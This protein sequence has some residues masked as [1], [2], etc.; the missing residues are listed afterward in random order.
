MF[1]SQLSKGLSLLRPNLQHLLR[2]QIELRRRPE[3]ELLETRNLLATWTPLTNLAP[4]GAGVMMLLTDGRVMMQGGGVT[5]AWSQ[6]TP[7]ATGSYINGTWSALDSMGL[8]RLYFASNVLPSGDVFVVGGEYSGPSGASNIPNTGEIYDPVTNTWS[9]IAPFPLPNFGD[10]PTELLADGSVLAGYIFDARTFLYNPATNSWSAAG[11][12]LR[13]DRSDEETW[14]KLPDGSV[15]SYDVFS[16]ISTGV[17]H[18]QRYIPSTNTWVDAGSF[19]AP[20]LSSSATGDELG[21]ALLLPDGRVFQI[22]SNGNTALYTPSTNTWTAGPT[23]PNAKGA[24][25]A[26]GAILPNGHVIFAADSFSPTFSPPTQVFDF[27]PVA[28]TITQ[29]VLPAALTTTLNGGPAFVTRMLMLPNGD[30]LFGT[31]TNRLWEYTPDGSPNASWQPT[32]SSVVLDG[33]GSYT[34]T[35]TQLSGISEGASY[36]DDAEMSSNYPIVQLTSSSGVVTYARTYNWTSQVAMGNT[37]ATTQFMLPSAPAAGDYSLRVIANGIASAPVDFAL[38]LTVSSSTPAN[39]GVVTSQTTSFIVNFNEAVVPTSVEASDLQVNGIAADGVTLNSA[40]T[41]ATFTFNTSPVTAQGVQNMAIA[42][43]GITG[44]DGISNAGFNSSFRYDALTLAV[45]S[46]NPPVG[47]TI[48]IPP[49]NFNFD[50]TFNEPID[51]ATV[52]PTDLVLSQGTVNAVTVLAGNETVRYTLVGM[53]T[54]GTLTVTLPAGKVKDAFDN[55][56]FTAFSATYSLDIGTAPMPAP[57]TGVQPFGSLVYSSSMAGLINNVTDTDNFTLN[58]DAGQTI[59]VVMHPTTLGLQPSVTLR[60]P[61][62]GVLGTAIAQAANQDAILE[63]LATT[64]G[65]VYTITAG[66]DSATT[67]GY[68]VQVILNGLEELER[69]NGQLSNNTLGTA[70]NLDPSFLALQAGP[71]NAARAAVLGNTDTYAAAAVTPTFTD[72][73]TTGAK[74]TVAIGDNA[75]NTLTSGQLAGFTIAF[76]GAT[77]ESLSFSTNGLITFTTADS[78]AANTD[79]SFSPSEP[80]IAP[81][82]D[83]LFIENSGTGAASRNIYWQLIGSGASQQLIIQWNNARQVGGTTY[84][85]FEA[86]LSRDG[87]VQF[88]YANTVPAAEIGS[89]TVGVKAAGVNSSQRLLVSFNQAAGSLV[90]PGLSTLLSATAPTPDFY[91]F[92]LNA[93]DTVTLALESSSSGVLNLTLEDAAGATLMSG[94]A[95]APNVPQLINDFVAPTTG[96]YYAV[97]AGAVGIDYTLLVN[98]NAEFGEE[99]F[100]AITSNLYHLGITGTISSPSDSDYFKIGALQVGDI[101]TISE[102]GTG[103]SRGTLSNPFVELYRAGSGT[104]VT[105]NDDGGPGGDSL[106]YRFTITT[107]DTYFVRATKFSSETG[108]Y[109][110]GIL[111][112]NTAAPPSTGGTLTSETEPNDSIATANDASTSWRLVQYQSRTSSK[113]SAGASDFYQYQL[114]AGDLVTVEA[115]STSTL[116]TRVNL[117]DANGAVIASEDG[118]STGP[119]ANSPIYAFRISATG[120]YFVQVEGNSGAGAYSANVYLSTAQQLGNQVV[121]NLP[122]LGYVDT[123]DVDRYQITLSGN[124]LLR[125]QTSTPADGSGEFVNA[126]DPRLRLFNSAGALVASD[127]NS[128]PDGRNALLS[129]AI[130]AGLGGTYFIEVASSTVPTVLTT[131]E[132]VLRLNI[133]GPATHFALS[134]PAG[135][136]AGAPA[137]ITVTALDQSNNT[138]PNYTGTVHFT[139]ADLQAVL[140]VDYTFLA[141]DAGVHTFNATLKTAGSQT[142]TALDTTTGSITGISNAIA[143]SAAAATLFNVIA[144]KSVATGSAFIFTVTALDPFNNTAIGYSGTVHFDSSD[145]QA[146]LPANSTLTNGAGSFSATM[147]TAGNQ[148]IS[149]TDIGNMSIAGVSNTIAVV[150]PIAIQGTQVN[151]GN[152]QRS[153]V[154]SLTVSF[155]HAVTLDAGAFSIVLHAN[156]TID[157]VI[158]QTAG[159]LPVLGWTTSNGGLSYVITFSGAG[160]VNNSIADGL[161]DL[162]LDHTKV[163][164]AVSQTLATDYVFAFF[165]LYG[166]FNG[167]GTVNNA[168]SFQFSRAFNKSIGQAGYLAFFDFNGDGTI[169]N[170][171]NFQ[172]SKRFNTTFKL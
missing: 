166:D 162:H 28:N 109:E 112:E 96:V 128:A 100:D 71:P 9:K 172:F 86:V 2:R 139:S 118:T 60:D 63:T 131:G 114:T 121:G 49:N 142:I 158:G 44:V 146:S 102:S 97:V 163:H 13:S 21:P 65:G 125:A 42:A 72:I 89:A 155:S 46:T 164:D 124:G 154:Q 82:W 138:V 7:S 74:S 52:A 105:F 76:F 80:V 101:I 26:P 94:V 16:S 57:L 132:Y 64:T 107:T 153:M 147:T 45:G 168:D 123:Q 150:A 143:V 1:Y 160:V 27:D 161:Y 167:D 129:Y 159:T 4:T 5:K 17:N 99:K 104:R 157:G 117:L 38:H 120:V 135:T 12:K 20:L 66:G 56:A 8:E 50:V 115:A 11:T 92:T 141:G 75:A 24:D 23:V 113:L 137:A 145:G 93:G 15:L 35:G 87:A 90:G 33:D 34:M 69:H 41:M 95:G 83:N 78:T 119:G 130:P 18:A 73:S 3:L 111:L 25:D 30:L 108:T 85:T 116:D 36:G 68:T 110:L 170:S 59:T 148:T 70:Q 106:I 103:S 54:E 151:D 165:R 79:L 43:N 81:L 48:T 29:V 10:D 126:L 32:I 149:A 19:P 136:I 40:D 88:N 39:G 37:P 169:N 84:F 122:I 6:L 144:P 134:G 61:A 14:T 156:A 47:S 91:S 171:D 53:T 58:V 51:P 140:P 127:D 62:N 133:T 22:G 152:A 67:G 55:P 31:S 98:R 77:Y